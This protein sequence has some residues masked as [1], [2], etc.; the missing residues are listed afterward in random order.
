MPVARSQ[1]RLISDG[2]MTARWVLPQE[3]QGRNYTDGEKA[4]ARL[5]ET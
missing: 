4:K 5:G 1:L 3:P 2:L